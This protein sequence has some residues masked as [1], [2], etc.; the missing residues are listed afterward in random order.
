MTNIV[1]QTNA[2]YRRLVSAITP[3]YEKIIQIKLQ[4]DDPKEYEEILFDFEDI[5]EGR[6]VPFYKEYDFTSYEQILTAFSISHAKNPSYTFEV[7]STLLKKLITYRTKTK[8]HFLPSDALD[9][10]YQIDG[11]KHDLISCISNYTDSLF[12]LKKEKVKELEKNLMNK[13]IHMLSIFQ[14]QK[15]LSDEEYQSVLELWIKYLDKVNVF[16]QDEEHGHRIFHFIALVFQKYADKLEENLDKEKIQKI[17]DSLSFIKNKNGDK[18]PNELS[19]LYEKL[20][21]NTTLEHVSITVVENSS[22]NG[23]AKIRELVN[24]EFQDICFMEVY[25]KTEK[26]EN[27]EMELSVT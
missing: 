16:F 18:V 23:A 14:R 27:P 1:T 17:K 4:G 26:L 6:D 9:L 20:L 11:D 24:N 10:F 22:N 2:K 21:P 5:L 8:P 12:K 25:R 3:L 19:A 15:M 13:S 7:L